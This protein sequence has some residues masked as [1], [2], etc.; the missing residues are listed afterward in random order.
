MDLDSLIIKKATIKDIKEIV[1]IK[2]NGWKSAYIGII[3]ENY[4]NNMSEEEQI[5]KYEIVYSLNDLFVA[6][7][8]N[9]VVGFC[10]VIDCTKPEFEDIE[11]DCEIRE[12]YVRPD[13]KRMGI[14]SKLFNYVLE[15]RIRKNF[16]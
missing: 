13:I 4:L 1:S 12:I 10:R 6:E 16:I 3:D 11:I 2:V 5:K 14:G 9:E 15:I 7:L 8:N